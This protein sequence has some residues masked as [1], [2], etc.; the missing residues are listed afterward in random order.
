[1]KTKNMPIMPIRKAEGKGFGV[2]MELLHDG[3][4]AISKYNYQNN[5]SFVVTTKDE[6]SA[7]EFYT[8]FLIDLNLMPC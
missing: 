3:N 1:M 7:G 4:Y 8:K 6:V 5:S 2:A